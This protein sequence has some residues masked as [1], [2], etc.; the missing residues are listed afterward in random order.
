[1]LRFWSFSRL[2]INLRLSETGNREITI[3]RRFSF[4]ISAKPTTVHFNYYENCVFSVINTVLRLF[5]DSLVHRLRS[6]LQILIAEKGRSATERDPDSK[7]FL[8][9]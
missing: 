2:T 8:A 6:P 1:M 4:Y 3:S 5:R 9:T 7:A